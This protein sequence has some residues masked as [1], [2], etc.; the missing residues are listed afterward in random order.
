MK[1]ET[2]RL[3]NPDGSMETLWETERK[4]IYLK[5]PSG[6]HLAITLEAGGGVRINTTIGQ[7][8]VVFPHASNTIVI[9]EG[10]HQ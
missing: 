2:Y 4:T 8:L 10:T 6:G 5:L 3:T 1:F 7:P 9:R